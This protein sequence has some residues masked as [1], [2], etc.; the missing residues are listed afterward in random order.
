MTEMFRCGDGPALTAFLYDECEPL[1]R[2]VIAAHVAACPACAAEIE[3]LAS[4]RRQLASWAPPEARL[5]FR[6][7]RED[8]DTVVD[9]R[10]AFAARGANGTGDAIAT[11]P[12][13]RRPMPAWAQVAAAAVIFATGIGVG[14]TRQAAPVAPLNDAMQSLSTRTDM[15][16]VSA[17]LDRFE[18]ALQAQ[19]AGVMDAAAIRQM[20]RAEL[21]AAQTSSA[22]VREVTERTVAAPVAGNR[23]VFASALTP[24]QGNAVVWTGAGSSFAGGDGGFA[25][26]NSG[27]TNEQVSMRRVEGMISAS[28]QAL[29]Q[30]MAMRLFDLVND[31]DTQRRW[32]REQVNKDLNSVVKTMAVVNR[33]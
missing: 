19:P 9:A 21:A 30:E 20:V 33:R 26:L 31:M 11:M 18:R 6:V 23:S 8:A 15:A 22:R 12:W 10:S 27:R 29:R 24:Y 14:A 25:A 3:E 4:T 7:T 13:W 16:R 2:E 17:R 32:D 28:E 5:G 1:E